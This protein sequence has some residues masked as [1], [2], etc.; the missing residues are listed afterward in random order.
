MPPQPYLAM[1][2]LGNQVILRGDA[3]S[4]KLKKTVVDAAK[5]F[6]KGREIIDELRI[7][8]NPPVVIKPGYSI[9]TFPPAPAVNGP[10]VFGFNVPGQPWLQVPLTWEQPTLASLDAAGLFSKVFEPSQAWPDFEAWLPKLALRK[11]PDSPA[12]S[13]SPKPAKP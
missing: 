13:P 12:P 5:Q 1:L 10:G 7:D 4:A 8:S 11:K 6:Y 3:G 2:A 9:T